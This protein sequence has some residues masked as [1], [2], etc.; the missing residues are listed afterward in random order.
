MLE[1][2]GLHPNL[3]EARGLPVAETPQATLLTSSK[4]VPFLHT[5]L[6]PAGLC[7][8]ALPQSRA[9]T[10]ATQSLSSMY[11]WDTCSPTSPPGKGQH[12]RSGGLSGSF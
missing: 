7:S 1:A 9:D 11:Y 4:P 8:L 10:V 5:R 2:E 6:A 12:Q 3:Q